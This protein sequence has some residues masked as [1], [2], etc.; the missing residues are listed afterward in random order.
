MPDVDDVLRARRGYV[1]APAGC[2]KTQLIADTVAASADRSLVLT[3]THAGVG[4]L[5][6]RLRAKGVSPKQ[7]SVE[8]IT[9]F[10]LRYAASYPASSRLS[11]H[12]PTAQQWDEVQSAA[13]RL[14]STSTIARVLLASF[15][16]VLVDEYQ[17]C[18]AL[19]HNL[20]MTIADVL[21]TVVFGDPLQGIF[22][23]AGPPVDWNDLDRR[24]EKL[25]EL[26]TPFR[27][28]D[29]S[30]PLGAWLLDARS[31]LL[32]GAEP[33]WQSGVVATGESTSATQVMTC[34]R[35]RDVDSVVAIRKWQRDEQDI[36][37]RLGG[38]FTS[39]ETIE[40]KDL[41]RVA[42]AFEAATGTELAHAVIVFAALCMAG[43]RSHLRA[44]EKR[45]RSGALPAARAGAANEG[46]VRALSDVVENGLEAVPAAL[47]EIASLRG[48]RTY[49]HE[50]LE[51]TVRAIRLRGPA[52]NRSLSELA[53]DLR[54]DARRRGRAVPPRVVSRTLLVKGLEFDHAIVL[55]RH[56]LN[57]EELYV[58]ITRPRES[59]TVLL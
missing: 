20:T 3:H 43:V 52:S 14:L 6:A 7:F 35:F 18:T 2:G 45:L 38:A 12:M 8:T 50:L 47:R 42:D 4:A 55:A 56:E 5:R 15:N 24:F 21:P 16:R 48:V 17:D 34:N 26:R 28:C 13:A 22:R 44:A 51:E 40:A 1:I 54:E 30:P 57:R 11:H 39:M 49:R 25:G 53:W 58:A 36:A 23:F 46:A 33:D 37:R 32:A 31:R 41:F 10:S 27:W 29:T 19:Q 9:G 59:L